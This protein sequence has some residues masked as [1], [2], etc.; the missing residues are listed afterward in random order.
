MTSELRVDAVVE[1]PAQWPADLYSGIKSMAQLIWEL[2]VAGHP[3]ALVARRMATYITANP[4][5]VD[6]WLRWSEN[7][8]VA[9]GW[10]FSNRPGRYSV[11]YSPNGEV[12][13]FT[14]PCLACAEFVIREVGSLL[15]K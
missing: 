8:R 3:Q 9:A 2:G 13:N 15:A 10:Y 7:K 6:Q 11:G 5:T 4:A 1:R 12:L 14:D